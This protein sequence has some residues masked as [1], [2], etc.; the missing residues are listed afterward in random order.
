M[1]KFGSRGLLACALLS[2]PG[3]AAAQF[4][5]DSDGVNDDV[6]A[7]PCDVAVSATRFFPAEAVF[8]MLQFEDLWPASAD[9]DFND[10]VIGENMQTTETGAGVVKLRAVFEVLASGGRIDHGL[11]ISL[12]LLASNLA[13]ATIE[14]NGQGAQPLTARTDEILVTFDLA[15]NL[16]TDVLGLAPRTIVNAVSG[17][18]TAAP[19]SIELNLTLTTPAPLASAQAPW[20]VFTFR[21]GQPDHEIH[22]DGYCGSARMNTALFGTGVDTSNLT[23]PRCFTD[24]RNIPAALV[25]P[26]QAVYPQEGL[27]VGVVFPNIVAWAASGGVTNKDWYLYPQITQGYAPMPVPVFPGGLS[28]LPVDVACVPAPVGQTSCRSLRDSGATVSGVYTIDPDG[29]GGLAPFS[30]YCDLQTDGG[31]WT[32]ILQQGPAAYTASNGAAGTIATAATNSAAKLSDAQINAIGGLGASKIYRMGGDATALNVYLKTPA[33]FNDLGR[34]WGLTAGS[35]E[36]CQGLNEAQCVYSTLSYPTLDT[37]SW[38]LAGNN[39]ERYFTDYAGAVDCYPSNPSQR[40]VN[41]GSSCGNHRQLNVF[42]MWVREQTPPPPIAT[43]TDTSCP[44]LLAGGQT[45]NGIYVIDPDG[46]GGLAP[47]SVY[48][49]M[50]DGG[51][52]K[53][54]QYATAPY[55]PTRAAAGDITTAN[56]PGFAKLADAYINAIGGLGATKT[57]RISGD[58]TSRH[59]YLQTTNAYNDT[60]QAMGLTAGTYLGCEANS[61]AA[62]AYS[63]LSL[64]RVDTLTWGFAGNNCDRYFTD[65]AGPTQCYGVSNSQRCF[66]AGSSCGSHRP[67]NNVSI[68]MQ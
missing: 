43:G 33:V 1:F 60:A 64:G 32:K 49:D 8:G 6:D 38:G 44:N 40:C 31:G 39:C 24:E 54:L 25:L 10:N 14:I 61:V 5:S 30:V 17:G 42:T 45:Q 50:S 19:G 65:Y 63:N 13:S 34:S 28:A 67:I 52:T 26:E 59:V 56:I 57:Y 53:I 29:S 16:A 9:S 46:S 48:C 41:A 51:W 7:Y 47:I 2:L 15:S 27:D 35:Y 68:F 21:T 62:C 58:A 3:T 22:R 12:P 37:L 66:S 20:D 23:G 4:D 11:A 36:G 18:T 55:G